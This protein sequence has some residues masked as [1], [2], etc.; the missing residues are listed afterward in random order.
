MIFTF[1]TLLDMGG[2]FQI[3]ELSIFMCLMKLIELIKVPEG[4]FLGV[5]VWVWGA[6]LSPHP[7][8]SL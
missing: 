3:M 6:F 5:G 1:F 4:C 2:G 8:P 7:M